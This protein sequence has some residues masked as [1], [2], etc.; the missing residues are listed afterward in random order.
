VRV[1]E[2]REG[3]EAPSGSRGAHAS[4]P[5]AGEIFSLARVSSRLGLGRVDGLL[6]VGPGEGRR[7]RGPGGP[8]GGGVRARMRWAWVVGVAPS[9]GHERG[10]WPPQTIG[11]APKKKRG[12]GRRGGCPLGFAKERER[13]GLRGHGN[14]REKRGR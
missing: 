11:Q 9:A 8:K 7:E 5:R 3:V 1:H 2:A 6:G 10:S 13:E 12:R 14:K 4:S